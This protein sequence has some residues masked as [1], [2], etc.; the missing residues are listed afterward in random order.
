VA[1]VGDHTISEFNSSGF[2][3]DFAS[4]APAQGALGLAFDNAG[5]LYATTFRS[6]T[7]E[8]FDASGVGTSFA[9]GLS[10]PGGLAFDRAGNLFVANGGNNTIEKFDASGVGTVFASS[11]LSAPYGLAFD[12]AGNLFVAN[13]ANNTIEEFD[14]SGAG[15]VFATGLDSP[16]GLAFDSA[17]NLFV[18]NSAN[19]TIE[20]FDSSGAG[21]VFAN[22][23]A[24]GFS[25]L[26]LAFQPVPEPST[27]A[28]LA[29]G[30]VTL[31]G[32]HRLFYASL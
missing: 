24:E 15:T 2:P 30:A 26:G 23:N 6:G 20:E 21:T 18:V 1:Y 19:N 14:S 31:I 29:L 27:W 25:T 8:K 28:L 13:K 5:N 22:L 32:S 12:S 17:G 4:V 3:T 9:T 11:G 16:A 7:I 10:L